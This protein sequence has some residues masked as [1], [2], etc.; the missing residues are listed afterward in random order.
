MIKDPVLSPLWLGFDP[1]SRWELPH[2]MGK[3]IT[4]LSERSQEQKAAC[5]SVC[6]KCLEEVNPQEQSS[7]VV[8]R[9]GRSGDE[10]W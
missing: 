3:K 2:A 8:A 10:E 4:M 5:D 1:W 7:F 6:I 9:G